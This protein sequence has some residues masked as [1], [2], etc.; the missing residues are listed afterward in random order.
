[1]ADQLQAWRV[2]WWDADFWL[3]EN[4]TWQGLD[5]A[6]NPRWLQ[7]GELFLCFPVA[8][9]LIILRFI[10][11]RLVDRE[12]SD[13]WCGCTW[14]EYRLFVVSILS[15]FEG[16]ENSFWRFV[17]LCFVL[18]ANAILFSKPSLSKQVL[19][20]R[21]VF[22]QA[23]TYS[24]VV[25]LLRSAYSTSSTEKVKGRWLFTFLSWA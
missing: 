13:F 9:V 6:K 17:W 19:S 14:C 5:E 11:E 10:F 23:V 24:E 7:S 21:T 20:S 18:G 12:R 15:W 25:Q 16:S 2:W 4:S 1:M 22:V 3:P 8:I